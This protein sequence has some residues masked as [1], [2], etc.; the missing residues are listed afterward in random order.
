[1]GSG[2]D[3]EKAETDFDFVAFLL[4][5]TCPNTRLSH[6]LSFRNL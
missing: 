6:A 4:C 2:I 5:Y 3:M 1:M